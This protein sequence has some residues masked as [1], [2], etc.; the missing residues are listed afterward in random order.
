MRAPRLHIRLGSAGAL[1][2]V[3]SI[4]SLVILAT[5]LLEM[6]GAAPRTAGSNRV[7]PLQF[8]AVIPG[9]GTVCQA[10]GGLPQQAAQAEMLIGT[11]YRPLPPLGLRFLDGSGR[12]VALATLSGGGRQGYVRLPITRLGSA[13]ATRFCLHDGSRNRIAVGGNSSPPSSASEVLNGKV[14][15]GM[16]SLFFLRPGSE[17]WWQLLPVLDLRFGL[18]KASFFGRWTLPFVALLFVASCAGALRLLVRE[19]R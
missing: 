10:L 4:G 17:T 1:V 12:I 2:A 11:Y 3:V 6:S 8:A 9:G 18:G 5:F 14:Q 7:R 13:A 15:P 19:L 16:V